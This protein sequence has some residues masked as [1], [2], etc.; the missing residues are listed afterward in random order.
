MEAYFRFSRRRLT[1]SH[2]KKDLNV[3]TEGKGRE[4]IPERR[5]WAFFERHHENKK[6]ADYF[7]VRGE[8]VIFSAV[9]RTRNS[10]RIIRIYRLNK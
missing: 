9:L 2:R 5:L 8:D 10:A 6:N 7:I 1:P 4:K 3:A